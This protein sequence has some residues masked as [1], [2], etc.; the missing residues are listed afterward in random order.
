M[1]LCIY[2]SVCDISP[3]LKRALPCVLTCP[4]FIYICICI[5]SAAIHVYVYVWVSNRP[6]SNAGCIW[7]LNT[8][9]FNTLANVSMHAVESSAAKSQTK[10]W[11]WGL[12]NEK[13]FENEDLG[14]RKNLRM[15]IWEWERIWEWGLGN[16]KEFGNEDLGM[17]KNL[18]MRIWE[19]ERIWGLGSE[20]E[21]KK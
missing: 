11:E 3:F 20:I 7:S 13:E 6:F 2:M 16:E 15:R 17:R 4:Q 21:R 1:F 8:K 14:M 5:Y 10:I 9:E 19:W 18:R 12:G